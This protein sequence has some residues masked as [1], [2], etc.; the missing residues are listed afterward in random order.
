[1]SRLKKLAKIT[2]QE[3]RKLMLARQIDDIR[4]QLEQVAI[5]CDRLSEE[6][7]EDQDTF[8]SQVVDKLYELVYSGYDFNK[9]SDKMRDE[10][11]DDLL[12]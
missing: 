7:G 5:R 11:V 3:E 10:V 8:K 12:D 4:S 1:M 2:L 6:L 9:V